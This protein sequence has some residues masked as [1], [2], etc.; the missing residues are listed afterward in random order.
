MVI[1]EIKTRNVDENQTH[2]I[3]ILYKSLYIFVLYLYNLRGF[4]LL[5]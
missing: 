4:G 5:R 3:D 1:P 2:I